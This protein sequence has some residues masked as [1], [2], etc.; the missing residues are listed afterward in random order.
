MKKFI[1][2]IIGLLIQ[3]INAASLHSNL[4]SRHVIKTM[5]LNDVIEMDC[6]TLTATTI[7]ATTKSNQIANLT[8]LNET[9]NGFDIFIFKKDNVLINLFRVKLRLKLTN[10][11]DQGVYE[12]GYY[13]FD[14]YGSLN[15]VAQ[16]SWLIN[17]T[18]KSFFSFF[19]PQDLLIN[20]S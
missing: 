18:G 11:T 4:A 20:L 14:K 19:V 7:T 6:G 3:L 1:L 9:L 17:I 16:K 5:K 13:R 15:Y 2:A 10:L 12:C 8:L